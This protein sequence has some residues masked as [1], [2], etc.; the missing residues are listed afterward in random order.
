MKNL[1]LAFTIVT[2]ALIPSLLLA[3][4][5]RPRPGQMPQTQPHAFQSSGR[6]TMQVHVPAHPVPI[7]SHSG[8]GPHRPPMVHTPVVHPRVVVV[9]QVVAT[10]VVAPY[11]PIYPGYYPQVSNG[12]S[13][14]IGGRNGVF[15]ISTGH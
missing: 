12:F 14:T 7:H 8:Y 2:F 15:S 1:T 13:L 10:P 4:P 3:Q 5:P 9:P 6:P 11:Y